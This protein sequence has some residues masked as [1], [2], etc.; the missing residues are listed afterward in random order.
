MNWANLETVEELEEATY[1]LLKLLMI[2]RLTT[3]YAYPEQQEVAH[4]NMRV[5]MGGMGLHNWLL[6]KGYDYQWNPEIDYW[7]NLWAQACDSYKVDIAQQLQCNVPIATRAYAPTGSI[8]RLCGG[9][10]SGCEPIFSAAYIWRYYDGN[11]RVEQLV[12][13]AGVRELVDLGYLQGTED[14]HDAYALA[15]P[16]GF[17]TR[18]VFQASLQ[19]YLDNAISSTVNLPAWGSASNNEDTLDTY[20]DTILRYLPYLRGL[21]VYADG[22]HSAQP[23]EKVSLGDALEGNVTVSS[24]YSNCSNGVCAT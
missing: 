15:A 19:Q 11:E 5:G 21:T 17:E 8:S 6:K 4:E 2:V 3:L 9:V 24:E 13:D 7:H 12:V 20:A 10:S 22:T 14:I 1:Y 18:L 16:E 23:M